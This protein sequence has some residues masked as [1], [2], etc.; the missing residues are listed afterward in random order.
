MKGRCEYTILGPRN[1]LEC[2]QVIR[3][4]LADQVLCSVVR[5]RTSNQLILKRV[6]PEKIDE[7]LPLWLQMA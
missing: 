7:P 3:Y 5:H 2:L 6:Y 4:T 1:G